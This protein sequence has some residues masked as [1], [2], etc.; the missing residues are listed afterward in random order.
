MNIRGEH[1]RR[2][3]G[4]TRLTPGCLDPAHNPQFCFLDPFIWFLP[5]DYVVLPSVCGSIGNRPSPLCRRRDKKRINC[6]K[7]KVIRHQSVGFDPAHTPGAAQ[8]QLLCQYGHPVHTLG[9]SLPQVLWASG[10]AENADRLP[11][12]P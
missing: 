4:L 6:Q 11:H 2:S 1:L 12:T 9:A 7:E 5:D 3:L 10:R 8:P